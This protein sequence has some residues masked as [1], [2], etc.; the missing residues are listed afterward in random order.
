[1]RLSTT[2]TLPPALRVLHWALIA[3]LASNVAYGGFQVFVSLA[4]EG[5]TGPLWGVARDIP[6]EH[7]V[8]RRL[9]AL[10]VWVSAAGLAVYLALTEYLPRLLRERRP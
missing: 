10:E 1:M 2:S 7:M 6:F 3:F 5:T 4:P 8:A 9:Y